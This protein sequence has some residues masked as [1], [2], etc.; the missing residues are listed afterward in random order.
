MSQRLFRQ[1]ALNHQKDQ[2]FG[3]VLIL[4]SLPH[5]IITVIIMTWLIGVFIWLNS[6]HY[7]RQ[8]SILGWLEPPDGVIRVYAENSTGKIKQVLVKEGQTVTKGQPLVIINGDR[9]LANGE[10]LETILLAEYTSQQDLL[11]QRLARSGSM[12]ATQ[13]RDLN[14]QVSSSMDD[15]ERLKD[16][17]VMVKKRHDMSMARV[18]KSKE[19]N[20]QGHISDLEYETTIEQELAIRSEYQGLT[21]TKVNLQN[22]IDQLHTRLMLMPHEHQDTLSQIQSNLSDMAQRIAQLH[23]D[24][25]HIIKA[26]RNGI[27]TNLQVKEGQQA[28]ASQPIMSIMPNNAKIIARLLIPVR[29]AGFVNAG[30]NI[31]IRY[32]AFPYQK[33]GLYSGTVTKMSTTIVLPNE[34]HALPM[35]IQE[36]VY[37]VQATLNEEAV[38]AY[39]QQ[40]PLKSGMTFTANVKLAERN[41]I[42]WI[43]EPI[44]SL[45][46][47]L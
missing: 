17:L 23:G 30:Q 24:R 45:K 2:L 19:M 9:V 13:L 43:L 21:R 42:E 40:F 25:A 22:Q 3:D 6:S 34:I 39:G 7:A 14:Q 27:V 33:F 11:N 44:F 10:H 15:M 16:Q 12:F 38:N 47:R 36:P 18:N 5:A 46:G 41:L 26:T 35:T 4:P 8:E 37:L 31:D 32:D 29:A 28:T 20:A 1:Q